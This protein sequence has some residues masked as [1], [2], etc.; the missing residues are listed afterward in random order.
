MTKCLLQHKMNASQQPC[1]V[2]AVRIKW[3]TADV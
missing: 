1:P 3:S 2:I